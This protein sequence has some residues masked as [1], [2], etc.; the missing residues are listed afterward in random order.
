MTIYVRGV[1]FKCSCEG[2]EVYILHSTAVCVH[3]SP[4]LH[5]T[6]HSTAV[7]VHVSPSLHPTLH[8][9]AVCVHVS[10]SLHP[11]LHSTLWISAV[12]APVLWD[13]SSVLPVVQSVM[14]SREP[15]PIIVCSITVCS[16]SPLHITLLS[17]GS[18][19]LSSLQ[20]LPRA[21]VRWSGQ[22]DSV[23]IEWASPGTQSAEEEPHPSLPRTIYLY[24]WLLVL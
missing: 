2:E 21:M 3:V 7:C 19:C 11:T 4:S 15:A 6:L 1:A 16:P 20:N 14:T 17:N 22:R 10:P 8:S 9:T 18:H 24:C 12:A 5:P 13:Q 23:L